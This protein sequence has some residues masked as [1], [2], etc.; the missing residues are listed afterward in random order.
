MKNIYDMK[1]HEK[2]EIGDDTVVIRVP[3][4]W[5]YRFFEFESYSGLN[6]VHHDNKKINSVFVPFSEEVIDDKVKC[7]IC[8]KLSATLCSCC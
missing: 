2:I 5:I 7:L 1:I 4:G 3:G 6:F 8:G